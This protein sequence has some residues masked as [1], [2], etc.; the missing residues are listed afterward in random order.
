MFPAR[1]RSPQRETARSFSMPAPMGGLNAVNGLAAMPAED[2]ISL[3]NVLPYDQGLRVRSG[4]RELANLDDGAAIRTTLPFT[5]PTATANR[6]FVATK[7]GIARVDEG[8]TIVGY[9]IE[10]GDTTGRAGWGVSHVV[11]TSAG[12][13]LVYTDE[14]N[15]YHLYKASTGSWEKIRNTST[16]TWVTL[17]PYNLGDTVNVG[18]SNYV[19]TVAGTSGATGPTGTGTTVDG[20][21]TWKFY[22]PVDGTID[23]PFDP[24]E[25]AACAVWKHRLFLIKRGSAE[26]YFLDL[27]AVYGTATRIS[28]AGRFAAGG[29]LRGLWNWTYDG[30]SGIDDRLVAVSGGGDVAIYEG[31]DPTLP[32]A[33]ELKGSWQVGAVPAGR[34]LCSSV[35]GDLL[36]ITYLGLLPLSKLVIGNPVVDRSQYATFKVSN[37]FSTLVRTYGAN[38]GWS[39]TM[40][41]GDGAL[42]VSIPRVD[43]LASE[44]LAMAVTSRA[45]G[46]YAFPRMQFSSSE[47]FA[48]SYYYGTSDGRVFESAGFTDYVLLADPETFDPIKFFGLT[49]YQKLG[50]ANQKQILMVRAN[51]TGDGQPPSY[52]LQVLYRYDQTE[53]EGG[54]TVTELVG[55]RFDTAV[56]DVDVFATTDFVAEQ[57][58]VGAEGMGAEFALAFAGRASARTVIIGFDF[59]YAVGGFL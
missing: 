56:F 58:T 36:L 7:N 44:Q 26:A 25:A 51:T 3:W 8:G 5:G 9:E 48:G 18:G 1:S 38:W 13:F 27:D 28:F 29:D 15:G 33:F 32:G 22:L 11:V 57:R 24:A 42:L 17:T 14:V 19:V 31:T 45:W 53:F 49:A 4:T 21:V 12:H 30:G 16:G 35:G 2:C 40:H 41:P 20:S 6:L 43:G 23:F 59:L 52:D 10:F 34:R 47:P 50:T 46:R 39:I 54:T 37:L 55:A